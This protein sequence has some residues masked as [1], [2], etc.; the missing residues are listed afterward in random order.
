V[1]TGNV[2]GGLVLGKVY[3]IYTVT[4]NLTISLKRDHLQ[5]VVSLATSS[6]Q[7]FTMAKFGDYAF[8]NRLA[9][10]QSIVKFNNKVYACIV[11]N[12]DAEFVIGKWALLNSVIVD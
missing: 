1:F 2:S 3:Y 4:P 6:F 8:L 11:S 10:N 7:N 12:N 9:F 5:I